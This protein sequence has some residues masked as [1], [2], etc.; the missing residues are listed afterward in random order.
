MQAKLHDRGYLVD[1]DR[2]HRPNPY[3]SD[4]FVAEHLDAKLPRIVVA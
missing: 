4:V 2:Q 1:N 3:A